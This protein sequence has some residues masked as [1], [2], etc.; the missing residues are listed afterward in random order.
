MAKLY[1]E[2][3]PMGS[4]KTT[5]LLTTAYNYEE[6]GG[7]R[8]FVTKPAKDLKGERN[9]ESR[10]GASREVDFL[11]DPE[12]DVEA[13]VVRR[14][15]EMAREGVEPIKAL[16]VDEAQFL[17]PK[18]VDQLFSLAVLRHIPVLTF[19]LRTDFQT[20]SFPG[21]RRLMELAHIIRESIAMCAAGCDNKAVFNARKV[22]DIYVAEGAQVAIDGKGET[23]YAALCGED[24]IKLVGPLPGLATVEQLAS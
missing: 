20:N 8:V 19:G 24:Y 22:N 6:N 4:Q 5:K 18:Q 7:R 21:S 9:I 14:N 15:L 13:E 3:G 1:F 12:M 2:Y 10:I 23:T 16:L 11:I 17:E